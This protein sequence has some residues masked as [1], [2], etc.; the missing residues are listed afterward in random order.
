M[1][2]EQKVTKPTYCGCPTPEVGEDICVICGYPLRPTLDE[3]SPK[4]Q[5]RRPVKRHARV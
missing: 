1:N 5:L 3:D 4:Y 2:E